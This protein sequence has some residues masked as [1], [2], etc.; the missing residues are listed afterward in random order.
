MLLRRTSETFDFTRGLVL[1]RSD[2]GRLGVLATEGT[3]PGLGPV[4]ATDTVERAWAT[5]APVLVK[6]LLEPEDAP[7]AELLPDGRNLLIVPLIAEGR[8]I[9]VLLA[10]HSK[11]RI[12]GR[13]VTMLAQFASHASLA[14]RNAWLLEEMREMADRDALTGIANRRSF[15]ARLALELKRAQRTNDPLSLLL[16]DLDHFKR[17][18]DA[19]GHL[20]GDEALRR[21]AASL[22]EHAREIDMPARYGGEE[23]AL[24][25]PSCS[26]EDAAAVA[27]R[28]REGISELQGLPATL[29]ASVGV[30][31][32]PRNALDARALLAA[33]D[34]ALYA[35]KRSGR[36]RVVSSD[37][38][39]DELADMP[40]E[41]PGRRPTGRIPTR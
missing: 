10:E 26:P 11:P 4:P 15:D 9:G 37:T 33:S 29:T 22:G 13:A 23:F 19:H 32:W 6:C 41:R 24:V 27:D 16:V 14:L 28:V 40:S 38:V 2:Y 25:L 31:S 5:R 30:A 35:A 36:D 1:A 7:L 12:D 8:P 3:E 21:V 20:S 18:N 39:I 34:A 17:L